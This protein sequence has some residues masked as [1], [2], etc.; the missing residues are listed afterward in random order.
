MSP[1]KYSVT[2]S[3]HPSFLPDKEYDLMGASTSV[4]VADD[5]GF[6]TLKQGTILYR[7]TVAPSLVPHLPPLPVDNMANPQW[8]A[9][10]PMIAYRYT[11][12]FGHIWAFQLVRDI[13]L[14][15]A[16]HPRFTTNVAKVLTHKRFLDPEASRLMHLP[17]GSHMTVN[18]QCKIAKDINKHDIEQAKI[19]NS[20][21]DQTSR[22]ATSG[23]RLSLKKVDLKFAQNMLLRCPETCGYSADEMKTIWH[24]IFHAELMLLECYKDILPRCALKVVDR[25]STI[26]AVWDVDDE[27]P[28]EGELTLAQ[29]VACVQS[30]KHVWRIRS[31][32][33]YPVRHIVEVGGAIDKLLVD[34]F[35]PQGSSSSQAGGGSSAASLSRSGASR[36][37][38]ASSVSKAW[39]ASR[40]LKAS[41]AS[42]GMSRAAYTARIVRWAPPNRLPLN[43]IYDRNSPYLCSYQMD[44]AGHVTTTFKWCTTYDEYKAGE[45]NMLEQRGMIQHA[46]EAREGRRRLMESRQ[47]ARGIEMAG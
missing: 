39:K 18:Q 4:Y 34:M 28:S 9:L 12:G 45:Q 2:W 41:K 29:I 35:F 10:D 8:F 38:W 30:Y 5:D 46:I 17:F 21:V 44:D 11:R 1:I 26:C 37:M 23:Q 16:S 15:N 6:V 47:V 24:G 7:G 20:H 31:M 27:L 36:A 40:A 19:C 22:T 3:T 32:R 13:R 33:I 25:E 43:D 14:P 42:T